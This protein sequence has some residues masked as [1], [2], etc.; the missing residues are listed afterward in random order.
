MNE[1]DTTL[2]SNPT[3]AD[4]TPAPAPADA[5]PAPAPAEVKAKAK[6]KAKSKAKTKKAKAKQGTKQGTKQGAG[7]P[8]LK[9]KFPGGKFTVNSL[10]ELNPEVCRLTIIN[11]IKR[12]IKTGEVTKLTETRKPDGPGRPS[13]LFVRTA[14]MEA[15]KNLTQ[16]RK[17]SAEPAPAEQVAAPA[18]TANA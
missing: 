12:E 15:W 5:T 10:N 1:T 18:E 2:T 3:A 16:G 7:R 14:R 6:S 9:L 4:A 13:E 11:H 8:P 17:N